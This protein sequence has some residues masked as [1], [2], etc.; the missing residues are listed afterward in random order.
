MVKNGNTEISA[1]P[2]VE[3]VFLGADL[4]FS[5]AVPYD[6]EVEYLQS[7]SQAYIDSGIPGSGIY[8]IECEYKYQS[9]VAYGAIYGNYTADSAKG[10]RA[11][12]GNSNNGGIIVAVRSA[13]T[14]G[15]VGSANTINAWHRLEALSDGSYYI[16]DALVGMV[17][18]GASVVPGDICI[19]NRSITNPNTD[20]NIGLQIKKFTI[21]EQG[22]KIL[23]LIPVRV[24]Q[25]GYMYD[26]IRGRLLGSSTSGVFTLG[27]DVI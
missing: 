5:S 4:V 8:S 22:A 16:D 9:F 18:A 1:I 15:Q 25:V 6:A 20:R 24:G 27:P 2:G 10:Y 11:I 13:F 12:L 26:K 17:T 14:A 23:D 19:F 21:K 3:K 7:D